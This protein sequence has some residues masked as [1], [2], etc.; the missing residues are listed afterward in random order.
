SIGGV[1][2][3]GCPDEVTPFPY[4]SA[5]CDTVVRLRLDTVS[6]VAPDVVRFAHLT[7][8]ADRHGRVARQ[9]HAMTHAGLIEA[10][11]PAWVRGLVPRGLA[12]ALGPRAERLVRAKHR[13]GDE[14]A[15]EGTV[16]GDQP[17]VVDECSATA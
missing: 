14:V 4:R 1:A 17:V 9:Q 11:E 15:D 2:R 10:L 3:Q 8:P 16:A 6:G 12:V 7:R 5:P 13:E